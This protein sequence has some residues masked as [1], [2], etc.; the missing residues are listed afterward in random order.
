MRRPGPPPATPACAQA[1]PRPLPLC[2]RAA[3]LQHSRAAAAPGFQA[4]P[5]LRSA[6]AQASLR[7]PRAGGRRTLPAPWGSVGPRATFGVL[8]CCCSSAAARARRGTAA[9][10]ARGDR[11]GPRVVSSSERRERP[12][13]GARVRS[14]ASPPLGGGSLLSTGVDGGGFS[15]GCFLPART[16]R[17]WRPRGRAAG[18]RATQPG[19]GCEL[20]ETEDRAPPPGRTK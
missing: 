20:A 12:P 18:R 6:Q 8:C 14:P 15:L 17:S 3:P 5:G 4:R 13:C 1:P 7:H 9:S 11:A 10:A 2:G 19:S 16:G